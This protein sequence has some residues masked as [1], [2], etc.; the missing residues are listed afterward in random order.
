M[1][2][3][4]REAWQRAA[5]TLRPADLVFVDE[6]GIA[7]NMGRAYGRAV[8]GRRAVGAL[9]YGRWE[10]LTL[11]GG[12]S[13]DGLVAC[14]SVEGASDAAVMVA[15]TEQVLVPVLH[16]GQVVVLDNLSAHRTPRVRELIAMAGCTLL[17]LP[18]YSP[19]RNPIEAAW[20]KLKTR[21][22]GLG[23]R[24]ADALNAALTTLVDAVTAQDARGFFR[25]CGYP[26]R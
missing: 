13:L 7:T 2:T 24:T 6:S 20:S 22:R 8:G 10:R 15:F 18:P 12:L 25:H 26:A 1:R 17:F 4:R 16:P 9:P 3:S 19:D 11:L 23:A 14:M 5:P 21:L